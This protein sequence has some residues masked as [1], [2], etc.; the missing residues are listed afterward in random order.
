MLL[1]ALLSAQTGSGE[2]F[3]L[4]DLFFSPPF[5]L[6]AF[7]LSRHPYHL[8]IPFVTRCVL[9]LQFSSFSRGWSDPKAQEQM[10]V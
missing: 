10:S 6:A 3:V 4:S 9:H 7:R 1:S 2:D 8:I 5:S